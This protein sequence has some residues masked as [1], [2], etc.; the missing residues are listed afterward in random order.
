MIKSILKENSSKPEQWEIIQHKMKHAALLILLIFIP[1]FST[2][3]KAQSTGIYLTLQNGDIGFLDTDLC[4]YTKIGNTGTVMT[5][6]ALCPNGMMYGTNGSNLYSINKTT[7]AITLIGAMGVSNLTAL[8]CDKNNQL[9]TASGVNNQLYKVNSSTGTATPT[10]NMGF[11]SA[12]DL[13]F[14]N[15][16]L[17]MASAN[18]VL[19]RVNATTP[20]QSA[21]VGT[22]FVPAGCVVGGLCTQPA[23]SGQTTTN[24]VCSC[25]SCNT[26]GVN[27]FGV[28]T[29]QKG[30]CQS[31]QITLLATADKTIYTVNPY[32][33]SMSTLCANVVPSTIYGAASTFESIPP[34]LLSVTTTSASVCPGVCNTLTASGSLGTPPYTYSWNPGAGTGSSFNVCPATTTTYTVV[35]TDNIGTTALSTATVTIKSS[36]TISITGTMTICAGQSTTLT[37]S[38]GG[39]YSWNNGST[40]SAIT[41]NPTSNTSYTLT[42]TKS[43]CTG[44]SSVAVT[45]NQYPTIS[46]SPTTICAGGNATITATGGP[47]YLW[48]TGETT[49]SISVTPSTTTSY[50]VT[51][52]NAGCSSSAVAAVI[53]GSSIVPVITGN[54]TICNGASTTL[55]TSGGGTYAWSDGS[56]GTSISVNPTTPTSY[57][58]TVT[59]GSCSGTASVQVAVVNN[60]TPTISGN[61]SVC[62]GTST[63]LTASGGSIYV[64]DNGQTTTSITV[65]P[66][67]QTTYTVTANTS[68]CTGQT[69]IVVSITPPP[70]PTITGAI[71]ICTGGST[72]LTATAGG[73]Y[74]WN[75][76]ATTAAITVSPTSNSTYTVIVT[77]GCS[78]SATVQVTVQANL[79][80]T[81]TGI[82]TICVGTSTTL[83]TSGGGTYAW[84]DGSTG[85]SITVTPPVGVTTYSVTVTSGLCNGTASIQ[86]TAT[87]PPTPTIIGTTSICNGTGTTLTS[88]A[89]GTYLWNNGATTA[90]I[91]VSPTNN[92]T[93]T[94]TVTTN[95]CSG[96]ATVGVTVN[97]TPMPS[98]TGSSTICSGQSATLTETGT[99]GPYSWSTGETT[100]VITVNPVTTTSYSISVTTNGCTGTATGN[101]TVIPPVTASVAGSNVCVGQ[102]TTLIASGGTTYLWD[103]GEGT[104]AI[105]VAPA[106]TTTYTVVVAVG[107]CADTATYT[108]TVNPLPIPIA[109]GDTTIL[110]GQ[111]TSLQSNG[112]GTYQWLPPTGL[113]CTNCSNPTASPTATTQYCVVVTTSG[114]SDSACVTVIVDL[115][116]GFEGELFVPNGF[117]PNN[118]GQNDVLYVRGLGITE[119]YWAIFD[120]WGEKVFETTD[121]T[122]GWDGKYK[123]KDLDPAVFVYYL[124]VTCITGDQ[125]KQKGNVAII[126]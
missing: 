31:N 41:V 76:G 101:I 110:Y 21:S 48:S 61:T 121:F 68:G 69:T 78:A 1:F 65:S 26:G 17:Y 86:V 99:A 90:A 98:I 87:P 23:C 52:N 77:T 114:C 79:T 109:S 81:I 122:Q 10:G 63:I 104:S 93:Y 83:S 60:P 20:N 56:T 112:G 58:V 91:T 46:V 73:V 71:F 72:T 67:S 9:W 95:N 120:R 42:V 111:S 18:N 117:S 82:N 28:V 59:N 55:S 115:K 39:T 92:T 66:P 38:G 5:D 57:S 25:T 15:D 29:I 108:V 118:D 12:G 13:T 89:G 84:S 124:E 30:N 7:A 8:V 37:G 94:V 106:S 36:P 19:V 34:C 43:G 62:S 47:G 126:K 35:M 27:V 113:S 70:A 100:N 6:I 85:T 88:N 53:V 119:M 123:G 54:T 22:M 105:T 116:C 2:Q 96:T 32:T 44:V 40:T 45:V 4:Q 97:P 51:V 80:P 33:A 75:T 50:T 125:I 14:Y 102:S 107:T 103:T 24:G 74:V 64:W 49:S 11:N 3:L 16:T